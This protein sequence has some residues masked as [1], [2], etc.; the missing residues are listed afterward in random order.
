M[1]TARTDSQNPPPLSA[2]HTL[3][4]HSSA[5]TFTTLQRALQL[6]PEFRRGAF[7]T[8]CLAVIS[9]TGQIVV[10][11]LVQQIVDRALAPGQSLDPWIVGWL[12]AGGFIAVVITAVS[13]YTVLTRLFG[14]AESGLS[15]LRV[16]AFRHVHDLSTLTQ[17]TE[18]RGSMV[19]RVTSDVDT[20][21]AFVSF[22]GLLLLL[23]SLQLV[24]AT[25]LMIFYS[26]ILAGVTWACF[27]PVLASGPLLQRRV[28]RAY[29]QVRARVGVML[30]VISE[31]VIGA[32]VIRAYGVERR[33]A[34][35]INQAVAEHR[36]AAVGSSIQVVTSFSFG[37]LVTGLTSAAVMLVG[38][39]QVSS[40][41]LT[42]GQLLAFLFLVQLFTGPV[43][44]G[45]EALNEMQNAIAGWRRVLAVIDLPADVVDPPIAPESLVTRT[46]SG[47]TA[48][49]FERVSYAYPDGPVVVSD[50]DVKIAA[51][52]QVAIVG[53]TGSGK[54][55]FAKLLVR[56]MDPIAGR[57]L[58]DDQ[59]VRDIPLAVLR[60]RVLLV[61]QE[62]FLFQGTVAAN[63]AVSQP[64]AS[65]ED[66]NAAYTALGLS[67]WVRGLP[68]GLATQVGQRGE[69]LSAGE[70]QLVA[71]AR[72]YLIDPDVLVLDEATSAVDPATEARIHSALESLAKGRTSVTIAHRLTT[73]EAADEIL[74]MVNGAIAERGP[75]VQLVAAGG[76]YAALHASWTA[77]HSS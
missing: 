1:S 2:G 59:D 34:E 22:G 29:Q 16:S 67:D 66:I 35:R 23:S 40:D 74:V 62:G 20:I 9:V 77:H 4:T 49:T 55:T 19:S 17:N 71:L 57:I 13:S 15:S 6:S 21:S 43:Q 51:G 56:L 76:H 7:V 72:A 73:A 27:L 53:E 26:P 58:L 50:V 36:A 45:V 61:P 75:A 54:S 14:A 52:S 63:T 30:S 24:V 28:A 42:L 46:R 31:A 3:E 32:P 37:V 60:S 38:T 39:Y 48:V 33:T 8:L 69:S 41:Q 65:V 5:S 11:L 12:L 64:A 18:R 68:N 44:V 47:P 10:P 70:R 25:G